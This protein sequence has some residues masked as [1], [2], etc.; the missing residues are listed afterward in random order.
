M[1]ETLQRLSYLLTQQGGCV[2]ELVSY[3][4]RGFEGRKVGVIC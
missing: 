2:F 4:H 1:N 3:L